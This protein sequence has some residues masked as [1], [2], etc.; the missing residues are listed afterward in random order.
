MDQ[1]PLAALE[2]EDVVYHLAV[3]QASSDD[4]QI[5]FAFLSQFGQSSAD[6]SIHTLL[7]RALIHH[8]PSFL[9]GTS[10]A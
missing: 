6:I 5:T 1:F 9:T 7:V 3:H 4:P 10:N 2:F 8:A